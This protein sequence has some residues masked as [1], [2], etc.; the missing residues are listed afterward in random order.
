MLRIGIAGCG[1]IADEH[2]SQIKRIPGCKLVAV[3]DV[4]KLMAD[5]LAARFDVPY[6]VNKIDEFL[7]LGKLDVVHI[8]T[9]PQSHFLLGKVFL[10]AG[11]HIY[12]EKPFTLYTK[13]AEELIYVAEKKKLKLTVGHDDQFTHVARAMRRM[14][15]EGFLGGPPIHMESYYCYDLSEKTYAKTFLTDRNHW[16]RGLPGKLAQ[17]VISHGICRIAEYMVCENPQVIAYGY[18]S[19]FLIE[20][21][22]KEIFDELRA[23]I[24]DNN[25]TAYFTFSSQMKPRLKQFRIYGEKN[26][27]IIDHDQQTIICLKGDRYRSYLERFIPPLSFSFQY[28]KN[29]ISNIL[30][31]IK[32][33]FH[34]KAGMYFLIKSFYNSIINDAPLPI[35]YIEIIKTSKIMDK[36]FSQVNKGTKLNLLINQ[37]IINQNQ[38]YHY[39]KY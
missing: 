37:E 27:I 25:M 14:V 20:I 12:V 18:S 35:P 39:S 16:I 30:R 13:E 1:K 26:A 34:M 24:Y 32:S 23:I 28:V 7:E 10:E 31:F 4:E 17:N 11:C 3:Y 38:D 29:S 9:P 33:D 21:G 6:S 8:T 36:I 2:A 19:P 5:Q 22:E 15:Q